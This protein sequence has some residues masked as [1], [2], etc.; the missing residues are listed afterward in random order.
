[1]QLE[2]PDVI[3]RNEILAALKCMEILLSM[4]FL[5]DGKSLAVLKGVKISDSLDKLFKL[6]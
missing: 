1:M 2:C 6:T 4:S 3:Y 5:F